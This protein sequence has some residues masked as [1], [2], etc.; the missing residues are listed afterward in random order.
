MFF[1]IFVEGL[2]FLFG[3][4]DWVFPPN[5]KTRELYIMAKER[6]YD[7]TELV[8]MIVENL[9]SVSSFD[10]YDRVY[11]VDDFRVTGVKVGNLLFDTVARSD[12]K[13]MKGVPYFFTGKIYEPINDA[14]RDRAV[15]LFLRRMRVRD[16][17]MYY[18]KKKFFAEAKRSMAL[19]S[20]LRPMF[21]IKAYRNGVVNFKDGVLRPFS[22]EFHVVYIHDYDYDPTAKCPIW[23]E[24]LRMV[25]PEKESRLILQMFLGLCT[26]DR[27]S[28]VDKVENCLML[29][30]NGSN[31]K[32]VIFDTV[33]GVFGKE[34]VSEMPLLSMIKG[35][36]ER[37]RNVA[38][39]DGKVVN[40]CPEVQARDMS[41]CED[42]FKSLCSGEP[43]YGR[44]I[45]GN[46]Y[47]VTNIP[48]LIFSM[49]NIPKAT[50]CSHGYFRRFL[51]V[52]FNYVVSESMQN[53]HLADDLKK[54]YPGILNWI[55]RGAYYLR[56]RKYVF[57]KSENSEKQKLYVV[58][59]GDVV[60]SW[61][62]A[63]G[64]RCSEQAKGEVSLWFTAAELYDD[65][66]KYAELNGFDNSVTKIGFA[67]SMD[68]MGFNNLCKKRFNDGVKYKVYGLSAEE[69]KTPPPVICDLDLSIEDE[70]RD[71]VEFDEDDL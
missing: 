42:A 25:L 70:L 71:C 9:V 36:D 32:G 58:G 62:L 8:S 20:P 47:A 31:G 26:M 22:S 33:R 49:N 24:F 34:N 56:R 15:E 55:R 18:S 6:I 19:N 1:T 43:Q 69:L 61:A 38:A 27:G 57:P 48:W 59:Q 12:L 35:G 30:G 37:L 63:R 53:K 39:I 7:S 17:D 10:D 44:V 3:F 23:R 51:Y 14:I 60:A 13:I 54:E 4:S 66:M 50:D 68:K 46:V 28:M 2:T 11:G 45:G 41:G 5:T 29:Y 64:V 67:K 40:F 52:I 65:M 21:H 16:R